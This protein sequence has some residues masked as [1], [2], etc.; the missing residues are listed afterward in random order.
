M[1]V[2]DIQCVVVP[3][4]KLPQGRVGMDIVIV[5]VLTDEGIEGNCFAWGGQAGEATAAI[6]DT[7]I[8]P[9]VVGEDPHYTEKIWQKVKVRDRIGGHL[10]RYAYG[11]V[12]VALWDIKGKATGLP[13]YKLLGANDDKIL[14]YASGGS[15][16]PSIE[17]YAE[18]ALK[19][20]GEGFKAYKLHP[21]SLLERGAAEK[22]VA[23]CT[24][25]RKAV[26]DEMILMNDPV[27]SYNFQ[28][29]LW[30]G[31]R[32]EELNYLWLEEPLWDHQIENY[33]E[34]CRALDIAIC[35]T[36]WVGD[37]ISGL[38][39]TNEYIVR[40][41]VDIVR[42]DVSWKGGVTG[43]LKTAA[44][45]EA[46]GM[47]CEIHMTLY[48]MLD[49]PNLHVACDIS[50]C[51]FLELCANHGCGFGVVEPPWIDKDGYVHAPQKPG[52]GVEIDWK[53]INAL[54]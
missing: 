16:K 7:V 29:A 43:L 36:E 20:K 40:R 21:P 34:L 37:G 28:Q 49:I 15:G 52:L 6:I 32:L 25:V 35:G 1:K 10:P 4:E 26:G 24:A 17:A 14:A 13:L 50:N 42:S 31:R 8:K 41:A 45:A 19:A 33:V 46:F 27:A 12:D 48:A 2:T 53:T 38:F 5:R 3:F 9:Q 18:D 11:P 39:A 47:Q 51:Q 30:V 44:L 54:L 23:A 22:D